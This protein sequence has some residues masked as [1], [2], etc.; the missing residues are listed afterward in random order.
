VG[1]HLWLQERRD[2]MLVTSER[3]A[4]VEVDLSGDR[5]AY[6]GRA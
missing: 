2:G 4:A 1:A 6:S 5:L 3:I